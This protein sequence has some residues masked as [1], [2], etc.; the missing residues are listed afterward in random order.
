MSLPRALSR[1]GFCSRKQAI[2]LIE[3]GEV[4]VNGRMV[5]DPAARVNPEKDLIE[6]SGKKPEPSPKVYL[7]LNKPRGLITTA[8]DEKGRPTVFTCFKDT[9]MPRIFP[10]GRLDRAS[11]GLLLFTN[12]NLWADLLLRP[13]TAVPRTYHVQIKPVPTKEDLEKM[14]HGFQVSSEVLRAEAV[15]LLRSGGKTCWLEIILTEGKN[16]HIRRMMEAL[17]YEVIRLIR[18]AFGP[19]ALGQLSKGAYRQLTNDEVVALE[20]LARKNLTKNR[21]EFKKLK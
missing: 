8:S 2:L 9:A 6:V 1:L 4:K 11:E 20:N 17:G 7:M 12:D 21:K 16:R 18:V 10:V 15:R 5:R 13:E 3:A 19:L 14:R